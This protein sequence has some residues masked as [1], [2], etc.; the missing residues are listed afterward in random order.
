MDKRAQAAQQLSSA[1]Q[2]Q[3]SGRHKEALAQFSAAAEL[4]HDLGD[5]A[6]Y[7][8]ALNGVGASYKDMEDN[9]HARHYLEQALVFRRKA[10]DARGEAITLLTLGPVYLHLGLS[11]EALRVLET[12]RG[13][14]SRLNDRPLLGQVM[15]NLA[16]VTEAQGHTA[17]A[18]QHLMTA[19]QLATHFAEQFKCANEAA[20]LCI[21]LGRI[22]EAERR[23][24]TL[25]GAARQLGNPALESFCYHELGI[26][27]RIQKREPEA[28]ADFRRSIEIDHANG[29]PSRAVQSHLALVALY[30]AR[31]FV[32][33]ARRELGRAGECV[34]AGGQADRDFLVA[35]ADIQT[36]SGNQV[37][38]R[39]LHSRLLNMARTAKNR[40]AEIDA[41]Y[42]LSLA[43]H[44]LGD[45]AASI[46]ALNAAIDLIESTRAGLDGDRKRRYFG[47]SDIQTIYYTHVGWLYHTGHPREA[48]HASES[49]RSRRLMELLFRSKGSSGL[50]LIDSPAAP[51]HVEEIPAI[52]QRLKQLNAVMFAY[53]VHFGYGI[54][55]ALDGDNFKAYDVP[56]GPSLR[57]DTELFREALLA[58]NRDSSS[59]WRLRFFAH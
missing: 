53:S 3:A 2:S 44:E 54:G 18:Y 46:K 19:G 31:G 10:A 34:P 12:A 7:G 32:D 20:K 56:D 50:A 28:E 4:F 16:Q 30:A 47:A 39:H 13:V 48:F 51:F 42:N 45:E 24:E 40:G 11:E 17:E 21:V 49:R 15:F 1:V 29:T 52:Q 6:S 36:A 43:E 35:E 23:V 58:S 14:V 59:M 25:L 38:V 57:R 55:W 33:K 5:I 41:Q 22:G 27:H 37:E 9:P 8:R 26:I